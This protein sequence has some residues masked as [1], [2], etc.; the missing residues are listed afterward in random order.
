FFTHG[1]NSLRAI[2]LISRIH[3]TLG[4]HIDLRQVF[5]SP[6]LGALAELIDAEQRRR[7]EAEVAALS[8]EELDRLLAAESG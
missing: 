1:G 5:G 2:Q 4:H 7:V 8:E 6:T 3:D